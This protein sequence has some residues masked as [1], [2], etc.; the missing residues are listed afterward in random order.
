M[1]PPWPPGPSRVLDTRTTSRLAAGKVVTLGVTGAGA[2]P[3]TASGAILNVTA[4]DA[5]AAGF[6]TVWPAADDGTCDPAARP[7]TS[8]VNVATA[9][10]VA[11][12]VMVRLGAG[13]VCIYA[14]SDTNVV[15]DLDGW[16]APG[17]G[18]VRALTPVR[19]LDTR[20]GTGG[21]P[22]AVPADGAV[23]VDLGAG[24]AG[25]VLNVTAVLPAGRGYLTV[26]P[27]ATDGSCPVAARPLASSL[28]FTAGQVVANLAVTATTGGKVC[29]YTQ[30]RTHIVADLA[31]TMAG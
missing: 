17:A 6:V 14:F 31:A 5:R 25:A 7:A 13:R 8:N 18:T 20:T 1:T 3:A 15:V 2:A 28:D 16:F 9:D 4:V 23:V 22:G 29:I 11:N 10:A 27:A 19:V 30:S 12:L 24:A 26:W 21:V